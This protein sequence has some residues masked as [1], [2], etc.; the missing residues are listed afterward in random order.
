MAD[1][2]DASA[3]FES[4]NNGRTVAGSTWSEAGADS[5]FVV[6]HPNLKRGWSFWKYDRVDPPSRSVN[7]R[8]QPFRCEL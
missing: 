8:M 6:I 1:T 4:P 5:L 2:R 3:F 7:N